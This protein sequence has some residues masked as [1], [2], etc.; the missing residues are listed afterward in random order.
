MATNNGMNVA[1]AGGKLGVLLVGLGA[2]STTFIAGVEAIR[3]GLAKPIGSLTQMSTIRL[4]KRTDGRSPMVKDFAPLADIN[5]LVFGAWDIFEEDAYEAALHAGVLE[6]ELLGEVKDF[7]RTVRPMK[8]VFSQEYVKRLNGTH[9]KTG[10]SKMALAEQLV[11]DINRFKEENGCDRLVMIW[12]ASTEV[13]R[14]I[15]E[16]AH[17]S[18]ESFEQAMWDNSD[19]ILPSMIY[20]YA[21]MKCGVPFANG[22]PNLTLDIP[23]LRRSHPQY[24]EFLEVG[25]ETLSGLDR[26]AREWAAASLP[27]T[28]HFLDINLDDPEDFSE[29]WLEDVASLA[30]ELRPA[31]LCGDAGMWHFGGREP[32][33]MLLLPPILCDASASELARGVSR[34]REATGLEVL[35]ENPPGNVFLGDMHLLDFF[36]QVCERADTGMLLDCAHL[37]IYQLNH[38]YDALHALDRFPFDRVVEMHVAGGTRREV[39]GYSFVDDDH[40]TEMIPETWAIFEYLVPRCR[41]LRAVIFECERNS[42]ASTLPGFAQIRRV[43]EGSPSLSARSR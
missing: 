30:R 11:D 36:A 9:V 33:Q 37:A 31:W 15:D 18:L 13:F 25:V 1:P 27:T 42:L 16:S 8:A 32:G 38:G 35:P 4:G 10:K 24:A 23:A 5:D 7:L 26:H 34:L 21:A 43:L 6:K 20:A 29:E 12:A 14:E 28:Y 3:R 39:D 19:A 2:V 41:N 22:A 17:G 40:S